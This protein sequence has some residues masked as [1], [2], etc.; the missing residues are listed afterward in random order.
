MIFCSVGN[1]DSTA[2]CPFVQSVLPP[3]AV[4][5]ATQTM[6]ED[7]QVGKGK[8]FLSKKQ[9]S[10]TENFPYEEFFHEQI[11][12]K[13]NDYS[14]RVF[15]KVNRMAA[16]FPSAKEYSWGERPIKV[17]CSNDY[18]GMS[19]HPEVKRAVR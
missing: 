5:H 6:L 1:A 18:L 15:K 17:W 13:K 2:N 9:L 14:Y 19:C 12:K 3:S 11:M 16:D 4:K 7:V 8:T 10:G